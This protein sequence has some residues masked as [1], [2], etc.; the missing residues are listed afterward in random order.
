MIEQ[1]AD[2]FEPYV[3]N[4]DVLEDGLPLPAWRLENIIRTSTTEAYN[5]GRL[6]EFMDPDLLPFLQGVRY[7]ATLD[8]RTT[9]VCIFLGRG[10]ASGQGFIF[11]P[12]SPDLAALVPPNHFQCRS[13][14]VPVTVGMQVDAGDFITPAEVG[15]ARELAD[16][17][18]LAENRAWGA[19]REHS[20]ERE[21]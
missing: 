12:T 15:K 4:A 21:E 9:E 11:K 17:R 14:I 18:F 8:E 10:G 6:T 5:Q 19:Y 7:S 20:D 1:L 2:L 16:A 13:L 3:G